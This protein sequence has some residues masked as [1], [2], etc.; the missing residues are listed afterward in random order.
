MRLQA[1]TILMREDFAFADDNSVRRNFRAQSFAH[2]ER[3]FEGSQIAVVH[4]NQPGL[5]PQARDRV[6]ARH[7]PRP[8]RPCADHARWC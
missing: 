1:E 7:A 2:V 5:Q 4:P 8:S 6:P 3:Y